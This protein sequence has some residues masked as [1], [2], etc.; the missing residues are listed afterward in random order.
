[1]PRTG[2]QYQVWQMLVSQWTSVAGKGWPG[3]QWWGWEKLSPGWACAVSAASPVPTSATPPDNNAAAMI[4]F[5]V[6][7]IFMDGT[8]GAGYEWILNVADGGASG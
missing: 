3:H 8:V 6:W 4:R 5:G 7:P 2:T 1:M